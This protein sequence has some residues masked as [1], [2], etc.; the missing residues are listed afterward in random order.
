MACQEAK[1]FTWACG[2]DAQDSKQCVH[3]CVHVHVWMHLKESGKEEGKSA[4]RRP[5]GALYFS[6]MEERDM[7]S[8]LFLVVQLIEVQRSWASEQTFLPLS[9]PYHLVLWKKE[10]LFPIC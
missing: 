3:V 5:L 7:L 6:A 4:W 2:K 1:A 10:H 8:F 9:H